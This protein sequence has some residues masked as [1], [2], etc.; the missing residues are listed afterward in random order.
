MSEY[1]DMS[2][3]TNPVGYWARSSKAMTT[4]RFIQIVAY[5]PD[6]DFSLSRLLALFATDLPIMTGDY[7]HHGH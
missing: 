7:A 3:V 2:N 6:I 5:D 4:K 1:K